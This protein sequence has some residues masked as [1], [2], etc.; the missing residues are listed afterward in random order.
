MLALILVA[1]CCV[2]AGA[3]TSPSC[4]DGNLTTYVGQPFIVD[5]GFRGISL[6]PRYRKDGSL[7]IPDLHRTFIRRARIFFARVV[8][9]DDGIY[10]FNSRNFESTMC[11]TG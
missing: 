9:S 3:V 11:L 10:Q 7:F 2:L 8:A 4:V 1:S 5:F 6:L